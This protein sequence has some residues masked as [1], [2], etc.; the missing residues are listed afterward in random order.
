M[1]KY[2]IISDIGKGI[3]ALLRDKLVPDVVDKADSIGICDP[4]E[5]GNYIV[6][7]H[8][9]DIKEDTSGTAKDSKTLPDGSVQDAPAMIEINY[10]ISVSSKAEIESKALDEAKII[11][12]VIQIFKDNPVIP[13]RYMPNNAGS[14]VENVPVNMLPINMEEKVKVWTMFGESYKL[15]VFYVVGPVAIDSGNI[16]K[17]KKR[18]ESIYIGTKQFRRKKEIHFATFLKEEDIDDEYTQRP[19]EDEDESEDDDFGDEDSGDE[20]SDDDFGDDDLGDDSGDDLGDDSGDDLGDD[21]GDDLGDDLGD[22]SGDDLGDDSGDDLGDDSGD[23]LGDDSGDDSGD[24]LGDDSGDDLG[25]D[26][27]DDSGDDLG[28][29]SGDD[30]GDDL[31]DDSGDDLGDDLGD[32]SGDDL[33]DGGEDV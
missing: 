6:G 19:D 4:K 18:V 1:A 30:S 24:D 5:R 23:D 13:A 10:V 28:D 8:P 12:K 32:D 11:G 2:T 16:H 3:L 7:I 31:G 9:Y 25:D 15:S 29:D 14:P 22:D 17:P 26:L 21:S 33:S 20:D 27:G